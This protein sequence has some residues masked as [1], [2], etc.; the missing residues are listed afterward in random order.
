MN[1]PGAGWSGSFRT[2]PTTLFD[3]AA[4]IHDLHYELNDLLFGKSKVSST[5]EKAY[6]ISR[7]AKADYIFTMMNKFHWEGGRW[8]GTLNF[9]SRVVFYDD[10]KYFCKGDDF[11]N[12]L[13]EHDS[14]KINDPDYTLMIPY[15]Q[16]SSEPIRS[17]VR[18]YPIPAT[19]HGGGKRTRRMSIEFA[20]YWTEV[21]EDRHPGFV[22]WMS[23]TMGD[24][25]SRILKID[26]QT[27]SS[28]VW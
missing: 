2:R 15:S 13:T 6:E 4:K 8:S 12:F 27:D 18:E 28:F 24:V 19:S 10:P 3:M 16:L 7:K 17:F 1:F 14:S 21:P 5:I 22:T 9:L 23:Q 26:D 25:Y 20:D 11:A